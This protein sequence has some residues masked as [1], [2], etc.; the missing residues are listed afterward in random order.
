VATPLRSGTLLA[1]ASAVAFGLTTPIISVA[2][3]G[4]GP[5][6]TAALLY[7]GAALVSLLPIPF[8]R[9]S[10]P[11]PGWRNAPRLLAIA[12]VGAVAAPVLFAWGVQR[13]GATA[14]S[15]ALN[16]EAVFS[17]VLARLVY[18]ETIGG[19]VA[20]AVML[21]A[22][23]GGL[24]ALDTARGAS[25]GGAGTLA[26]VGATLCWALDNTLTRP[27]SD[28]DLGATVGAKATLGAAATAALFV[29]IGEA[30]PSTWQLAV[31]VL[32][33]ATG[34]GLS[35]RLYLLAQRRIG[36]GRTASVFATGPFVGAGV[37]WALGDRGAS[38][39]TAAGAVAFA[40]GVYLH[41]TEHH[42]HPHTHAATRHAHAHRHDDGHHAHAHDPPVVGE[43]THEHAHDAMAHEHEH[44][45][46]L[47][48]GHGHS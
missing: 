20:V 28:L 12:L 1:L 13:T 30:T 2:G 16:L 14:A 39:E 40:L 8:L 19:R 45:P 43:H 25:V 11:M 24:V 22:A 41:A 32:C 17:V 7:L 29:L 31:L 35:L 9:R 46:D 34:Y 15:L 44:G 38:L 3:R 42:A 6:A 48:H 21:M 18:R 5:F 23:G 4:V 36:A 37:A 26:I 33:G 27:L 10:G 47:H